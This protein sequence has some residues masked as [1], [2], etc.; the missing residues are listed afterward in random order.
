MDNDFAT[1]EQSYVLKVL[2]FDVPCFGYFYKEN[3]FTCDHFDTGETKGY[4]LFDTKLNLK[5]QDIVARPLYQQ[6]F[7]WV[8]R[9]L[10]KYKNSYEV[11]DSHLFINYETPK[12]SL[13]KLINLLAKIR[14]GFKLAEEDEEV[15]IS[16][17][18]VIQKSIVSQYSNKVDVVSELTTKLKSAKKEIE[19]LKIKVK[20]YAK[21]NNDIKSEK[22]NVK[23]DSIRLNDE[24][25]E[26]SQKIKKQSYEIDKYKSTLNSLNSLREKL[27]KENSDKLSTINSLNQNIED[28]KNKISSLE[29]D[30]SSLEEDITKELVSKGDEILELALT[31]KKILGFIYVYQ[32]RTRELLYL[33]LK[34]YGFAEDRGSIEAYQKK[35][36]ILENPKLSKFFKIK[37]RN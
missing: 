19:I 13:D 18:D 12:E 28:L 24:V 14:E 11:S 5:N 37:I 25:E 26:F 35:K 1:Y 36:A 6:A 15:M 10:R 27:E 3:F 34:W 32:G 7:R 33:A 23:K 31:K 4:I 17:T 2:G 30:I 22:S 29:N 16:G 20:N 9:E 8:N 21:L